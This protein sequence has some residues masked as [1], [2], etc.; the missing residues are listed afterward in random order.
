MIWAAC[1]LLATVNHARILA[2]HGLSWDYGGVGVASAVYWSGLTVVDPI[3]AALLFIRPTIGI[4]LTIG[5]IT[6]NVA[7]NLAITAMFSGPGALLLRATA[8][9]AIMSQ[10]AFM[11]FVVG[12]TRIAWRGR[13]AMAPDPAM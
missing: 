4:P 3:A 11:L 7:H 8:N 13:K 1:L 12:T 6:T 10:I 5:L 2:Q 9:W